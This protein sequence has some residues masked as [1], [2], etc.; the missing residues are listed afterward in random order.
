MNLIDFRESEMF[1]LSL[2]VGEGYNDI[3]VTK[4]SKKRIY[5]SNGK[6]VTIKNSS[7][8]LYLDSA[9]NGINQ[10]LRDIEGFLIYKVYC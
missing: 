8:F 4:K 9:K 3:I 1:L 10:I 5:L 7:G 2:K 6:I